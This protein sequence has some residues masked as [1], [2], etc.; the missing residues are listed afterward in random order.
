MKV[1]SFDVGSKN[2]AVC[3]F[4]ICKDTKTFSVESWQVLSVVD[5][6]VNVNKTNV[7]ELVW[8]FA[9]TIEDHMAYWV[10]DTERMFIESQPMGRTRNLKTKI[11]S[12][13][14]QVSALRFKPELSVFFIHPS[15]KLKEMTGPR[16]YRLNKKYAVTK[17]EEIIQSSLC[18][19][20]DFCTSLFVGKKRDD[21]ADA[22][23][24]GFYAIDAQ[25]TKPRIVRTAASSVSN[26]DNAAENRPKKKKRTTAIQIN[27]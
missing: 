17:T 7:E 22:F 2:L 23:L 26:E 9:K 18:S 21:L 12:H 8:P 10:L 3:K 5:S 14:L 25:P 24:Q 11:L 20:K 6:S 13:I 19:N 1:V 15:L 4:E 16:E 27:D